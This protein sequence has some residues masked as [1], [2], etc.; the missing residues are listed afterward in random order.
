MK[1]TKLFGL[2]AGVLFLWSCEENNLTPTE[3][4]QIKFGQI[5][6]WCHGHEDMTFTSSNYT[7]SY[8]YACGDSL[9]VATKTY[10]M[11]ESLWN[12][13]LENINPET[14]SQLD[15]N[16]CAYCAD[17]CDYWLILE[18]SAYSHEITFSSLDQITD[19]STKALASELTTLLETTRAS[20]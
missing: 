5:C 20:Q 13:I 12:S 11:S 17:G 18:D 15:L 9:D 8:D 16:S 19:E 2:L 10:E 14:F 4:F 1:T 7:Y 6:G 3:A